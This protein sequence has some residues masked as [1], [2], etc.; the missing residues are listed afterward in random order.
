MDYLDKYA[1]LEETATDFDPV[2]YE[3]GDEVASLGEELFRKLMQL[4]EDLTRR[5][6]S[7]DVKRKATRDF[8]NGVSPKPQHRITGEKPAVPPVPPTILPD[9]QLPELR[10]YVDPKIARAQAEAAAAAA[11]QARIAAAKQKQKDFETLMDT[12][13]LRAYKPKNLK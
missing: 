6:A 1:P 10:P 8:L 7:D 2:M 11:E 9:E 4:L 13:T 3:Y 12:T 5:G